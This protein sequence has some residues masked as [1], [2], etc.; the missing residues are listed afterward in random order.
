MSKP[1]STLWLY[2][3]VFLSGSAVMVIEL[4]GTRVI[5]PFYGNSL[6]VW[7]SLIS[8]TMIA[9]ALGYYIGGSWADRS[10]KSS[11]SLIMAL[12]AGFTG[13]IP[14]IAKPILMATD[15]F[16]LRTG[17]FLSALLLFMPALTLLGMTGP[18]A[19]KLATRQLESLGH[20]AGSIYAIST[21]GSVVGTLI[22]GFILFPA[23]GSKQIL[24][25]TALM[26][27]I[28]ASAIRIVE[29]QASTKPIRHWPF[30]IIIL[31]SAGILGSS[32][33]NMDSWNPNGFKVISA[34]E[35][36]YGW[37]KVIDQPQKD[38]RIL[39]SDASAIGAGTISTGQSRLIYQD[40]VGLL[41]QLHYPLQRVLIVGLGA[42][43]M[44]GILRRNSPVQIDT[45]EIDPL[46][47]QAAQD[48]FHFKPNGLAIIGDARY[49]IRHLQGPYDLI[50]HD[51][52]TG[53]SE[54]AHLLTTE[55]LEQLKT[56]LSPRGIL[57]L[58]FVGFA[59]NDHNQALK[60]VGHTL[61]HVFPS[62]LTLISEPDKSFNDFIFL[63]SQDSLNTESSQLSA[64]QQHWLKQRIITIDTREG[65]L[66]TDNFNPLEHLQL[67]KAEY[68]R[69]FILEWLGASILLN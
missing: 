10:A 66:L 67:H 31:I 34:H 62:T 24:M 69:H 40:I 39:T 38:L 47:A 14:I 56:L 27:L 61:Q 49:E 55:T 29:H 45:L 54:P 2:P 50:I 36:L 25:C 17:A 53:G 5:A 35:S 22:L 1:Q 3:T 12:A 42:G 51:C 15:H 6:Y 28:I 21:L 18:F 4:L 41:P 43:H 44:A 46:V 20:T 68:Y 60:A 30:L 9:L 13:L 63:A 33:Q 8:V 59:E 58:N 64:T 19:I 52:F 26:L 48:Y 57:A 23:V 37:V 65:L 16:G 32:Q 7:S 11:L